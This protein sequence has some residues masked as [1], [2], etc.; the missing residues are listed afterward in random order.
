MEQ[1]ELLQL[2]FTEPIQRSMAK[3]NTLAAPVFRAATAAAAA[4]A[5]LHSD[6]PFEV[7]PVLRCGQGQQRKDESAPGAF[8]PCQGPLQKSSA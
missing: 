8:S 4:D 7:D 6:D 1:M 2:V 3:S 5:A